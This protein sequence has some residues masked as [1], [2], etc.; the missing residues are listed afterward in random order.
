M[1]ELA[2]RVRAG[3]RRAVARAITWVENGHPEKDALL[4]RLYPHTGRAVRVGITG[5]PGAGKSSL[6]DRLVGHLR[7]QGL[8]VAV[9]AVDPTSPFTGGALLGDR[10]RMQAHATDPGVF[11]RSMGTRGHL[12]GLSRSTQDAVR[13]LDAAGFDVVLVETVGVGQSEVDVMHVADTTVVVLTPGGGDV[14]QAFK[15]GIMEIADIFVVNKA[16]LP[17]AEKVK[18]QVEAMLDFVKHDA[19]WRPPVVKTSATRDAGLDA[20][21]QAVTAHRA[22]LDQS[23]EGRRQ[24]AERLR[25]DVLA[26][27]AAR[28]QQRLAVALEEPPFAALLEQVQAGAVDPYAAAEAL[29]SG[30]LRE[31]DRLLCRHGPVGEEV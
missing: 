27:A 8:T 6:V 4:K 22:Y 18:A 23:G 30:L 20:L 13:V 29:V 28:L 1:D 9:V 12:G 11:I 16:D 10:V 5:A 31:P 3:D 19:P 25:R 17:G 21:W 14:V 24:R 26:L 2:A 7:R 15:A